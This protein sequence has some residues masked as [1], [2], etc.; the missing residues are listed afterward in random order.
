MEY[1]SF[2]QLVVVVLWTCLV[3]QCQ[4]PDTSSWRN[5][6]E[7][8]TKDVFSNRWLIAFMG[9]A[10]RS[11]SGLEVHA[12]RSSSKFMYLLQSFTEIEIRCK[13]YSYSNLSII[14]CKTSEELGSLGNACGWWWSEWCF[15]DHGSSYRCRP[16]RKRGHPSRKISWLC[17]W[18][19]SIS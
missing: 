12:V 19:I 3:R 8:I 10:I 6:E 5:A 7:A 4:R 14:G 18:A 1:V 2:I 16:L 9:A 13:D 15:N 17:H 11:I